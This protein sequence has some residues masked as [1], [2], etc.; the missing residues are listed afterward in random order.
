[1]VQNA[2]VLGKTFTEAALAA[3]SAEP[4]GDLAPALSAVVDDA[5]PGS[6]GVQPVPV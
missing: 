1:L 5:V 2:S 6:G 4:V 3:V